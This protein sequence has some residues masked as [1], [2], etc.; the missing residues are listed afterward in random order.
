MFSFLNNI[1]QV[2]KNILLL[3]VMLY[4]V[5]HVLLST[6]HGSIDL[7]TLLSAHY[8][9][10]A[11]FEPYQIISHM[12]MHSPQDFLHILFNMLILVMFGAHLERLWGAKRFFIFYISCGL[13]AFALYNAMGVMELHSFKN[14]LISTGYDIHTLNHQIVTNNL[15]DVKLLSDNS[16]FL[17][18][19]YIKYNYST[20]L[21]ASGALFGVLAGFAFLFPNTE[22]M[23]IF[24]PI[25]IKAK[26]LIGGYIALE[27]FQSLKNP[28]DQIA[29]LA[30]V[31]G[32]IVGIIILLIW[33][34]TD[35][36]NFW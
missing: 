17:L 15:T 7:F 10:S 5:S 36:K 24:P 31:G 12:F 32:A 16:Q 26:F 8:V 6:S 2:T 4:I 23:L 22:L 3:N 33:R 30:H 9:N 34:R 21:G 28:H 29:H 20:M 35:R 1:P 27:I 18:E 14:Q 11:L 25:P 13:G 19:K